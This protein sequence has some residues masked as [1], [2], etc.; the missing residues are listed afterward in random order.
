M[1]TNQ[2]LEVK[3]ILTSGWTKKRYFQAENDK[4]CCCV[5]GAGQKICNPR[6]TQIFKY[7]QTTALVVTSAAR[8]AVA[9]ARAAA[10]AARAAE[11]AAVAMVMVEAASAAACSP[12]LGSAEAS[13]QAKLEKIWKNRPGWVSK[14]D[15]THGNLNLHYLMGMFGITTSF[16]DCRNTSLDMMLDKLDECAAWTTENELF[17]VSN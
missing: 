2:I 6:V 5:H 3:K 8:A 16:N 13:G 1:Y 12:A 4:I 14:T 7:F 15:P 10:E 9:A 17:L 11:E